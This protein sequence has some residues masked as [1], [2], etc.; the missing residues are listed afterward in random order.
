MSDSSKADFLQNQR[1]KALLGGGPERVK[2]QHDRQIFFKTNAKRRC[3]A[4]AP[5][6]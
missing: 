2:T 4:V 5:S 3:L 6:V 1:E